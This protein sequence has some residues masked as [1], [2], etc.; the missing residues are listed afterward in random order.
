MSLNVLMTIQHDRLGFESD[1]VASK[2][3]WFMPKCN[4]VYT[5]VL[6]IGSALVAT[7]MHIEACMYAML[8]LDAE[9]AYQTRQAKKA[10]RLKRGER[11]DNRSNL[12]IQSDEKWSCTA[13][14]TRQADPALAYLLPL[15]F[16]NKSYKTNIH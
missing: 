2:G 8:Q 6:P 11:G 9:L 7:Y 1:T 15:L 10:C 14:Y 12:P 16:G 5:E 13:L 4:I 3:G